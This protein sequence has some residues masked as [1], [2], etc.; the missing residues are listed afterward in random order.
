ME[1]AA[2]SQSVS[3]IHDAGFIRTLGRFVE[4]K[5]DL[6]FVKYRSQMRM[7]PATTILDILAM[8]QSVMK[9]FADSLLTIQMRDVVYTVTSE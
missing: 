2:K 3:Q 7:N 4:Q 5:R 9:N 1:N 8:R 6:E